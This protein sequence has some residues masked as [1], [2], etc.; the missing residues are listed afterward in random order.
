MSEIT[1]RFLSNSTTIVLLLLCARREELLEA[2][3]LIAQ[4]GGTLKLQ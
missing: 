2:G 4:L 3:Q 1:N